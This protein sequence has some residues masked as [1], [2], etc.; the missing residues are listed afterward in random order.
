MGTVYLVENTELQR[1]EALKVPHL[2][3]GAG[4]GERFLREARL[5]ARLDHPNLCT[6]HHAGVIDGVYFLTMRYLQGKPLSHYVGKP[7]PPA[8]A[9][10]IVVVLAQALE[11]AHGKGVI[12]R[13]LKP[14]NVMLCPGSGPTIMDFGLAKQTLPLHPDDKLT[15]S[16]TMLGT[17]SYMPPEQVNGELDKMGPCSDVYSLGV[18][19]FELL[20]G[21]LPFTGTPAQ[22]LARV[23]FVAPPL[24]SQVQPGLAAALDAIC[25][26]TMAKQPGERFASMKAFAAA[27][28]DYLRSPTATSAAGNQAARP[29]T[30]EEI[31]AARTAPPGNE[32]GAG[33][34]KLKCPHCNV[35]IKVKDP[36]RL[37]GAITCPNC[38]RTFHSACPS[39]LPRW[40]CRCCP[41]C[42]PSSL[43]FP[44][45]KIGR[46]FRLVRARAARSGWWRAWLLSAGLR[47]DSSKEKQGKRIP[48]KDGRVE[49]KENQLPKTI[50]NSIGM[51]L[52]LIP[53][54][55]F[56]MG[57][58]AGEGSD[59][60]RPQ[61]EVE[62][63]KAFYLGVHEVTQGQ[64]KAVMGKNNNPSYFSKTG[65]GKDSVKD[66]SEKQLD[67]FPVE[68]VSWEDAQT[69][70][71]KLNALAAEKKFHLK[72]RLP[73]E[74]EWEYSCRGGARSKTFHYG[75]SLSST[76]ANFD[77][78]QPYGGAEKGPY[79]RRT[80][81]VGSYQPNAFGLKDMHG[82]VWEWCSDWYGKDYYG[83]SP[84][85]D[86]QG[87]S[88][89]SSRVF[90]GGSWC[91][92]GGDCRSARRFRNTPGDRNGD[93]G[94][95][96]AA[97]PAR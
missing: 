76:Q 65:A 12:H 77:G 84:R 10:E 2:E 88:E 56:T 97:V 73:T 94:F 79:L 72:Y 25:A 23:L 1:D 60:E 22:V 86:P 11:Y 7:I 3:G 38:K 9:V 34:I 45:R 31:L 20:T 14:S 66:F 85:R 37:Q 92:A 87:P 82:N 43:P 42:L 6:V 54:G 8:R 90:R 61:H 21:R 19:L 64:W 70:L 44:C 95:R 13:D 81:K 49:E 74:A 91:N 58:P 52:V 89:G 51:K 4:V 29:T 40:R 67:D 16:G 28:S 39:R 96:V 15:Q 83:K 69:F 59:D 62:I 75:N 36:G 30:R 17:P 48:K 63:T 80:C 24:P 71:K 57:S 46:P 50:T 53:A 35:R 93:V 41:R 68:N 18:I 47:S 27:L 32:A 33:Q 5:A 78:N 26:R 55:R